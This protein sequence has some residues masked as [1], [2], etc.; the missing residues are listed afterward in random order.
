MSERF[1]QEFIVQN[2]AAL[3]DLAWELEAS[4]GQ[5]SLI[6]ARC[7]YA[8]LRD[9]LVEHLRQTCAATIRVLRLSAAE[10]ALYTRIQDELKGEQPGALMVFGLETMVD[11]E[12]LL[13]TANQVREEFRKNCPFPIVLWVT[14]EVMKGLVHAAP[15]LESWA[16]KTHFTLP[17]ASLTQALKQAADHLFATLFDS[18]AHESLDTLQQSFDL[19]LLQPGEVESAIQDLQ[20]QGQEINP[21]LRASLDFAKGLN[22]AN[23]VEALV[24]LERSLQFWQA[25]EERQGEEISALKVGLIRVYIGRVKFEIAE[26]A[27]QPTSDDWEAIRQTLQ[28]AIDRFEQSNRPDLVALCIPQLE[29]VLQK[30]Q[31]WDEL[32]KI[33]RQGLELH[34]AYRNQTRLSQDYGFLARALLEQHQWN[35]A[36]QAAQQALAA[37]TEEPSS[38]NWLR[39]LYRLFLAQTERQLGTT[40]PAIAHLKEA[41]AREVSHQGYPKIAIRIL[42]ELRELHF[43][44]KQYLEAFQIKQEWRSIEQQYGIRAFVGAGRLQPQ[45]QAVVAEFQ[46]PAEGMVAPEIAAAGRQRDL[47]RLIERVE[48]RDYR[49]IV[50]HGS[51]GVGK[52]SLVNAGLV[53]MLRQRVIEVRNNVPIVLRI[54]TQWIPD[55]ARLFGQ[56]LENLELE[57]P[58]NTADITPQTLLAQLRQLDQRNLRTVLIFD[59][60]EEFFFVY[61]KPIDRKPFFDFLA[62]CLQILSV[63]IFL[64]LREDYLHYLLECNR[65]EAI[66]QTGIDVLG[67]N[68]LYE[69]GNFHRTDAQA[70]VQSLTTRARFYLEPSL[71]EQVVEDLAQE[72]GEVRPIELQVVGAQLQTDHI[73]TLAQYQ[74]LGQEPKQELVKRYL[75]EVV[76]DCGTENQQ[77]AEL[78]LFLLTDEKGTRPLKTRF[79]LTKELQPL[80]THLDKFDDTLELVLRIFVDSGLVFLLPEIPADRYQLVHDYLATF[81]RQQQ[82]PQLS[83]LMADLTQAQAQRKLSEQKLNRLLKQA[84]IGAFIAVA[85]TSSLA[86]AALIFAQESRKQTIRAQNNEIRAIS[87]SASALYTS[88]QDFNALIKAIHAV[89]LM[90]RSGIAVDADIQAQTIDALRQAAYRVKEFNRLEGHTSWVRAIAFSPNGKFLASAGGDNVIRLWHTDGSLYKLLEGHTNSVQSLSFSPDGSKLASAGNDGHL[91]LWQ[92]EGNGKPFKEINAHPGA[93]IYAVNF[94]PDGQILASADSSGM[95]KL[96]TQD[97]RFLRQ[98]SAHPDDLI[99]S[100]AFSPD[101]QILL[102]AGFKDD[103]IKQWQRDGQFLRSFKAEQKG[104]A[105]VQFS[106]DGRAIVSAGLDG[107]IK[108]WTVL[109]VPIRKLSGHSDAVYSA[110]FSPDGQTIAST[111]ADFTVKLWRWQDG[112]LLDTLTGHN[113][114]VN[115]ISFSLDGKVLASASQ[116]QT[117]KLWHLDNRLLKVLTGHHQSVNSISFNPDGNRLVS[118]GNSGTI[119]LWHSDGKLIRNLSG[120]RADVY[121]V[122]FNHIIASVDYTGVLKLWDRDGNLIKTVQALKQVGRFSSVSMSADGK[123]IVTGSEEGTI[124]LWQPD[125]KLLRQW[126]AGKSVSVEF[127]P[128]GQSVVSASS[129]G[130]LALWHLNGQ[131]LAVIE[132]AHNN[133]PVRSASFSPNSQWVVSGG[134]DQTMRLWQVQKHSLK[135]IRTIPTAQDIVLSVSFSPDGQTLVSAGDNGTVKLWQL[136]GTLIATLPGHEK[137]VYSL[138]FNPKTRVL[139]TAGKDT[140]IILWNLEQLSLGSLLNH[141]CQWTFD[142]LKTN[143]KMTSDRDRKTDYQFC[144]EVLKK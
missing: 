77:M 71:V 84:L 120:H 17:L 117:I 35:A 2:Q 61:P 41:N 127:S 23:P 118:G 106:P 123:Y 13:S 89:R 40:E 34:Q 97:G 76:T 24:L 74:S 115:D 65:L 79:D 136:D 75:A 125:G 49:L 62:Q 12:R 55:L 131:K 98:I 32:A 11:L 92:V 116:D 7:N 18:V 52:S 51:S 73:T 5:F 101:S 93:K 38:L 31:R 121:S 102:S 110:R 8:H 134:G 14:D 91:K 59:Q 80:I 67:R 87:T 50:I 47:D 56:V 19:G 15:D 100:L 88:H 129:D 133:R 139:A 142:F 28:L 66:Q 124:A 57:T 113:S 132:K 39:G 27:S 78:V 45:R 82:E 107:S 22:T 10:T 4:T 90:Q 94:S 141:S 109:G 105:S 119:K 143:S 81:I 69:L 26:M 3:E 63:K 6:L 37:L 126:N 99:Y 130:R 43:A 140:K 54:Y 46:A 25:E 60:F 135:W 138:N 33:A 1:P 85:I 114:Y 72:L 70:I 83:Q 48:R 42:Q 44:E 64:S 53:P 104:V 86:I 137:G 29:R 30:L 68:V 144:S 122:S 108:L 95:I 58:Q 16:T 21:T 20:L 112:A 128:N 36:Q 9:G 111:S 96:W 103:T